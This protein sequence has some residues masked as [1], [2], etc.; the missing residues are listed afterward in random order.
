MILK[1]E[2][3]WKKLQNIIMLLNINFDLTLINALFYF[4]GIR[5]C[6][7][8]MT[9]FKVPQ[10]INLQIPKVWLDFIV[11]YHIRRVALSH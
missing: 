9:N 3:F 8:F 1:V 7:Y 2:L 6:F 10:P 11:E 5:R 4:F